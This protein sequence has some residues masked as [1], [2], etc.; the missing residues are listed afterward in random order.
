MPNTPVAAAAE[1]VPTIQSLFKIWQAQQEMIQN[2]PMSESVLDA[3]ADGQ[4]E[5]AES[6]L[7]IKPS[8]LMD[9]AMKVIACTDTGSA[10]M[11]AEL[12]AEAEAI[13]ARPAQRSAVEPMRVGRSEFLRGEDLV[14][15]CAHLC[16]LVFNSIEGLQLD[17]DLRSLSAGI[18]VIEGKLHEAAERFEFAK[19]AQ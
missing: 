2:F 11:P 18:N 17:D 16:R 4:A 19:R 9:F 3:A 10:P 12:I 13:V 7:A 5:L 1:G 8:T 6:I 15:E 14:Y